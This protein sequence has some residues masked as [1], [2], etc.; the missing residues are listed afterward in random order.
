MSDEEIAE[1]LEQFSDFLDI[2][3]IFMDPFRLLGWVIIKGLMLILDGLEK[4]TNDVLFLKKFFNNT[5]ITSFVDSIQPFLYIL[6]AFSILYA[7]Y[8]LIFQKK[9]NREGMVVNI[10]ISLS[11][12]ALLST[13]MEKANEFTDEAIDFIGSQQLYSEEKGTLSENIISRNI[14]DLTEFDQDDWSTTKLDKPNNIPLSMLGKLSIT[15]KFD[16]SRKELDMSKDGKKISKKALIWSHGKK[17]LS[18]MDQSGLEWNNS[19]YYRYNLDWISLI[20]TM[21]VMAF[22][23]I[24]IS[25]KLARL[26]FELAF[27]YVLAYIVAPV[28]IHDGQKTKKILQSILN[29]FIVI[30]L[31]FLSMKVYMIGTSWLADEL[32]GLAY[33][34]ALIAFSVAVID[35]P[36]I[37]ERL[38]GIDAGLKS[39]WGVMAGAYT[40]GKAIA[41]TTKAVGRVGKSLAGKGK[42]GGGGEGGTGKGKNKPSQTEKPPSP[43]DEENSTGGGNSTVGEISTG[44]EKSSTTS[45]STGISIHALI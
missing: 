7:G 27:N 33:I 19:Y 35:G 40:G 41:G 21:I 4:V 26:S 32:S 37:V 14:T 43:N 11:I 28:D 12:I 44:G 31:I 34:I 1:K 9:F 16:S 38:F 18:K 5:E 36:N 39:G 6:L 15:E 17:D 25:Y 3:N 2:G 13:G 20:T 45:K 42:E 8:M 22:T 30:I 29:T 23:L 10:F 24:S